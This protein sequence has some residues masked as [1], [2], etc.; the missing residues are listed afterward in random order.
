MEQPTVYEKSA[1][2]QKA[3]APQSTQGKLT[4]VTG[5]PMRKICLIVIILVAVATFAYYGKTTS[6]QTQVEN[7]K[8]KMAPPAEKS[9]GI[10][11]R[12]TLHL[13]TNTWQGVVVDANHRVDA[14][15]LTDDLERQV[16]LNGDDQRI[17]DRPAE[18]WKRNEHWEIKG[19]VNLIE[20]R[21]K[22]GQTNHG[23]RGV[24]VY[25]LQDKNR[26]PAFR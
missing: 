16:R 20:W 7:L 12:V 24:L 17:Y 21:I 22:P 6:G 1:D 26:P 13:D 11:R 19:P 3:L 5:T 25:V 2:G 10:E 9:D 4:K 8:N 15:L 14:K 18:N 23:G